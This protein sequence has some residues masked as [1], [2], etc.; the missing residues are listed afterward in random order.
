MATSMGCSDNKESIDRVI[1]STRA[2]FNDSVDQKMPR[3]LAALTGFWLTVGHYFVE[4]L[5][6]MSHSGIDESLAVV[7]YLG[8]KTAVVLVAGLGEGLVQANHL[9]VLNEL[10]VPQ[11]LQR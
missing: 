3:V 6:H 8:L 9:V 1:R 7:A 10:G 2:L 4:R 5:V 11:V